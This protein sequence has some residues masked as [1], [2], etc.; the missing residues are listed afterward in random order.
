MAHDLLMPKL[1]LTMTEG[2]VSEWKAKPGDP[3][4]AGEVLFVIE[5]DKVAFDVNAEQEGV[6]LEIAVPVGTTVAVGTPLGRIGAPG[7]AAPAAGNGTSAARPA[8]SAVAAAPTPNDAA[9]R[10]A[11]ARAAPEDG[12]TRSGARIV[13][14]PLARKVAA[15][16]GVD[17]AAI[18]GSGPRGRI[19]AADV[20]SAARARPTARAA[21]VTPPA[22]ESRRRPSSMQTTMARRLSEVKQGVPHFYLAAEAEVSA[23]ETL[24]A[25][26]NVDA[27]RPRVTMTTFIVAAAGRALADL[28]AANTVWADGELVTFSGTDVGVAVNA[29]QGLYVPVVRDAGRKSIDTIAAESRGLVE[30]ARA[31]KLAREDMA[32]GAFSVS[33][34]GMYNVTYMTPIV[35]PGQSAILGVGSV[36]QVFRPD[37]EGK[38]A[39]RRELG[40]VLAADHRVFDGV[41]GLELLNRIIGYLE[42]PLRLLRNQ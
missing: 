41:S 20:E 15:S 12:P 5:T 11:P 23:L 1:G 25:T 34:A 8:T 2:T 33:N 26:L 9:A 35:N 7:E 38:P 31:A 29:P 39:L 28:P 16:A 21:S 6:L 42:S 10:A 37:A 3:V 13:A 40:L 17:L 32:G 14:T 4:K 22:Q 19:K 36:R 24:R 27:E 30:R 18:T